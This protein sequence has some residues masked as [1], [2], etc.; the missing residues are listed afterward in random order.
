MQLLCQTL[1][2]LS[3][4]STSPKASGIPTLRAE[5]SALVMI[6]VT[7]TSFRTVLD[8]QVWNSI[9]ELTLLFKHLI[10]LI[11]TNDHT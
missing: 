1:E 3:S 11:I 8:Y 9:V 7:L 6:Q 5:A 10:N 2:P 4:A